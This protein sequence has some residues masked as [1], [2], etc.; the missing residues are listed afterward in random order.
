MTSKSEIDE[1]RRVLVDQHGCHAVILYGSRARG[2][3]QKGSDW[4]VVGIRA[5]GESAREA[6]PFGDGWL[7]AFVY[8]EEHFAKI[9]EDALRL[10]NGKILVDTQ[11]YAAKLLSRIAAFEQAGP[12]P[13][14][15]GEESVLRAWYPKMLDRISRGD[16]EAKYRRAWLL[17]DALG[18]WFRLRRRWYRGPKEALAWLSQHDASAHAVFAHAL[19]PTASYEDIAA[20]VACVLGD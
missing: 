9:D 4:D 1:I 8:A 16:V 18:D 19:E 2:A 14:P 13:L 5:K 10:H 15:P 20:L 17:H 3:A 12:P 7:D 6:R 11:G